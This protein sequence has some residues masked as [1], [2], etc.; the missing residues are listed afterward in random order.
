MPLTD[1][2]LKALKGTGKAQKIFDGGGLYI[3]VTATGSLLWRMSYY[4]DGKQRTYSLGKYPEITLARA[5][6]LRDEAKCLVAEGVDPVQKRKEDK[7][8]TREKEEEAKLVFGVVAREWYEKQTTNLVPRYRKLVLARVENDLI[9]VIGKIP[10]SQIKPTDILKP[11]RIME[12]RG[13]AETARRLC[14]IAS[15]ICRYAV[16]CGYTTY[17]AANDLSRVLSKP[18]HRHRA[19]I[20]D[21]AEIGRLLRAIDNYQGDISIRMALK[22]LPYTFLRSIE[23]REGKWDEIDFERAVWIVPAERMKRRKAHALPLARQVLEILKNLFLITGPVGLLFPSPESIF[24]PVEKPITDEALLKAIRR[25][26]Y[27]KEEMC[28]HG[29][30]AIATTHLS[31]LGFNSEVVELQMSHRER[32]AVRAAYNRSQHWNARVEMMQKWADYLDTLNRQA[33]DAA[34]DTDL[35]VQVA[36]LCK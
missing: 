24:K 6:A 30:R 5:R 34:L 1:S 8:I 33:E 29:F 35:P 15:Q 14:N 17:N 18:I 23:L 19:A 11:L 21:A 2:K 36:Q 27:A 28:V 32:D 20:L 22:L 25:M 12:G 16:A 26:G 13:H 3:Y 9:P 7:R 10:I 4:L 31:E